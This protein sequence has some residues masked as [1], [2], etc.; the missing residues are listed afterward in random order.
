MSNSLCNGIIKNNNP[1]SP[2]IEFEL[3][4]MREYSDYD[5]GTI[6]DVVKSAEQFLS[7]DY[8][9]IDK[10]FYRIFGK[11]AKETIFLADFFTLNEAKEYLYYLTGE[12]PQIISY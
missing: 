8:N 10:P 1:K 7:D 4:T 12:I 3:V 6:I 9:P 5:G 2:I 11:T